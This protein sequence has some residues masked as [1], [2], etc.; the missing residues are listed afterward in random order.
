[1]IDAA[2]WWPILV[3]AGFCFT[4]IVVFW[5]NLKKQETGNDDKR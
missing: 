2:H 3:Y 4:L 1:M 5:V